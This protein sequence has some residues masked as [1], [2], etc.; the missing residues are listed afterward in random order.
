MARPLIQPAIVVILSGVV[1]ALHIGKLPPAIPVLQSQLGVTL[2]QAGF[3]L[4][5]IQMAGM[6]VG[7]LV[8]LAADGFGLRR[9]LLWGLG[10]LTVGSGLG[11]LATQPGA[12]LALRALEGL[13]VLLV[14][15]PAPSLIRQTVEP[16]QLPRLLG[17]WGAYMPTGTALALLAGPVVLGVIGWAGWWFVL[18]LLTACMWVIAWQ[19]LPRTLPPPVRAPLPACKRAHTPT[20]LASI[21]LQ[22]PGHSPVQSTATGA[23]LA[24]PGADA[25]LQTERSAWA[26]LH[27]TLTSRGPWLVALAFAMYSS[28][29]LAVVGFLPSV[30]AQAGVSSGMAGVA[31]A[32]VCAANIV[33]NVAAGRLLQR[34]VPA[35]LLLYVGFVTMGLTALFAFHPLTSQAVIGRYASVLL[36]SAIGGVVPGTLFSMAVALAPSQRTVSTTV[37]WVQQC[38]STGQFAGPPLVAWVAGQLGGWHGTWMVTGAAALVG[39]LLVRQ[40]PHLPGHTR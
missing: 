24:R 10:V 17:M 37:G 39:L 33:G 13:G 19:G 34:G 15:L 26:R 35:R 4:S 2:L 21:P 22:A 36:F 28:Q 18:A 29:W 7:V 3:L 9:S 32:L 11:A 31:T 16:A 40:L 38:S 30:Y 14:A 27:L 20:A 6:S 8:G 12:L 25:L 1:A 5:M 23:S